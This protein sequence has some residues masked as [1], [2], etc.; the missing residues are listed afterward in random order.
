MEMKIIKPQDQAVGQ[1]DGGKL[2]EQKPIGFSGEGSLINR[3]GPL[4]YWAWGTSEGT[5]EIGFHPHQGFE[6]LT[7]V[8]KG[9]G[10]HQD[11]LGTVSE[12]GAG[13]IQ[14]MQT[15]SGLQHAES[16]LEPTEAFQI[17]FEPYLNEAVKRTPN[18]S[19]Y[20]HEDFPIISENGVTVK[21]LLG[22]HSPINLIA[23]AKMYDVELVNGA[24]YTHALSPNRTL[25]GL[26]IRGNGVVMDES[27]SSFDHK[28]FIII[29][30][31]KDETFTVQP[32]GEELRMLLIEI[33]TEVEYP[34][35][36]KPR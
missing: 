3:L 12:V 13:G 24:T 14:V 15:G 4:F 8:I 22:E 34:L 32:K 27:E 10:R 9:A 1:F 21:T 26:A 5:G 6:I 23:D 17:W 28:D 31:E 11:T 33:P 35:Y 19:K 25:A 7:Y 30:S 18:Y 2:I 16:I 29:Q 20:E 36:R